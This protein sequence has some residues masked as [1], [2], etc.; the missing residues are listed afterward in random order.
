MVLPVSKCVGHASSYKSSVADGL[1][2]LIQISQDKSN[3][4]VIKPSLKLNKPT[5]QL[6]QI[7]PNSL[8]QYSCFLKSC[9]LCRK[10]LSPDKDV[11]MYRGDQGFCT[12]ECRN[13]QIYLDEMREIEISTNK[14]V[15]SF[16]HGQHTTGRCETLDLLEEFRQRR[17]PLSRENNPAIFSYS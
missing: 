7:P 9:H 6:N 5:F 1:R 14:I 17:N 4:V 12:I 2:I 3:N 13:R 10:S 11:Y 8:D 16:R 15:K